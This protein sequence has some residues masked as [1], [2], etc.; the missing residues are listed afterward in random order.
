MPK[1]LT[2]DEFIARA[3]TIHEGF[4][5]YQ[6]TEYVNAQ[7]KVIVTCPVHGDFHIKATNHTVQKQGCAECAGNTKHTVSE[8][9]EKA[10]AAH[11]NYYSYDKVVYT[12]SHTHVTITCPTHGDFE[13][14]PYVHLQNHGCPACGTITG[15][16]KQVG[17]P[18]VYSYSGWEQ[19]ALSSKTFDGFSMYI[20]FCKNSTESFIK[21]GKTFSK[22]S[23]RFSSFKQL[24]YEWVLLDQVYGSADYISKLETAMH[25]NLREFSYIPSNTFAGYKECYNL[26]EKELNEIKQRTTDDIRT[27]KKD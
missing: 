1:L 16:L 2:N 8:F 12:N 9:V 21:V 24:P 22:V 7:T 14:K 23:R 11:N 20:V 3:T 18:N 6:N 10:K 4:Y 19:T 5:T 15:T 17:S 27:C 25:T 13:Q 26:T